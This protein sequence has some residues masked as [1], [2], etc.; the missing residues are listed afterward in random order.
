MFGLLNLRSI[1]I[2]GEISYSIYL[3]HGLVLYLAI[4]ELSLIKVDKISFAEYLFYLST[5]TIFVVFLST[6]TFLL[7]EYPFIKIGKALP[8]S[9]YI[10]R[11][12]KINRTIENRYKRG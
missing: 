10:A 9:N 7:V 1:K 2:L 3:L 11:L 6:V 5:L 8:I 4:T 12:S